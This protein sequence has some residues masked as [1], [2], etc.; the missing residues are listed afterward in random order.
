MART[1]TCSSDLVA[2]ARE[3]AS[4]GLKRDLIGPYIGVS[5]RTLYLWLARGKQEPGSIYEDFLHAVEAGETENAVFMLDAVAVAA[6][7]DWRAAQFVLKSR[8]GYTEKIE[9]DVHITGGEDIGAKAPAA[10]AR[11]LAEKLKGS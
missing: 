2:K 7:S 1:T 6:A 11:E 10:R 4:R 8:H 9:T 3:A 5:R